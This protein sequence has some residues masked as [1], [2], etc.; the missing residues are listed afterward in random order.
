MKSTGEVFL[1]F[2][3]CN[4]PGL[5]TPMSF[6]PSGISLSSDG[7]IL[8][9]DSHGNLFHVA[10]FNSQGEVILVANFFLS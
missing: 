4:V 8:V 2:S 7:D 1:K 5:T 10:V 9:G 6:F 3:T